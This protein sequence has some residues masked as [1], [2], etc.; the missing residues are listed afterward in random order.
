MQRTYSAH[1]VRMQ[2]ACSAHAVHTQ[3]T[4]SAHAV[5]IEGRTE[6]CDGRC[7]HAEA[8]QEGI[9]EGRVHDGEEQ[10]LGGARE[11]LLAPLECVRLRGFALSPL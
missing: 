10:G 2:C 4:R 3:C 5:L 9:A 6:Q 1:A 11:E 7:G 8:A